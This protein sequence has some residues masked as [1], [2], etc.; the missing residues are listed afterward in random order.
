MNP[1]LP[2]DFDA[3]KSEL[4]NYFEDAMRI[5]NSEMINEIAMLKQR[6]TRCEKANRDLV[7]RFDSAPWL[8]VQQ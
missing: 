4:A 8:V 5:L 3:M 6:L 1:G 2:L 7:A